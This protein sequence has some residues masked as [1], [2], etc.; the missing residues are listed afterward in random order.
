MLPDDADEPVVA[1]WG[2]P[3]VSANTDRA[4]VARAVV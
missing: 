4:L 1:T 3:R 2:S